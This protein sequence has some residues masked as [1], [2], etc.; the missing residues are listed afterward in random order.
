MAG[1]IIPL[2]YLIEWKLGVAEN[3]QRMKY[4]LMDDIT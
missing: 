3:R 2:D 1:M 4:L